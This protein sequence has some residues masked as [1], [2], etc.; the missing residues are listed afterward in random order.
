MNGKRGL[1]SAGASIVNRNKRYIV[2]FY[3]FNLLFGWLGAMGL[4]RRV[5]PIL[6]HSLHA[7]KLLHGFDLAVLYE[8]MSRPEFGS[9]HS[10]TGLGLVFAVLFFVLSLL[11]MPGVL[12]GYSSD[13]RISRDEFFRACGHNFWRFF[14]LFT[15]FLIIGGIVAG[16]LFGIEGALAKAAEESSYELLPFITRMI[17]IAIIFVVLTTIRIWF[18]LAQTDVVLRDQVATRKSIA[19]GYRMARRNLGRVLGSYILIAVMADSVLALGIVLWNMIVPPASVLGAFLV[20]Q[21]TLLV[22]L[23]MRFW[24]RATAVSFYLHRAAEPLEAQPAALAV[25]GAIA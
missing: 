3:V 21:A 5:S 15:F 17:G 6:N 1:I 10:A 7:D 22:F 18:D 16:I 23:A 19:G 24:Q 13:H 25:P 4:G 12:L 8:M 11:F 2:W 20:S 14:R 9:R